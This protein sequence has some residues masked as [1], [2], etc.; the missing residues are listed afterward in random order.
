MI[1]VDREAKKLKERNLPSEWID[2]MKTP[3]GRIHV[4]SLRG[5]LVHDLI[6]KALK[7]LGVNARFSYVFNNIDPMDGMPAYL[8][9]KW[10]Q[11]M[12]MPLYKI[13]SPEKG[14]RNF[15][16]Y[17]AKEF[18][19]VFNSINCHPEIIWSS[20][21][22][23][24]GK[25]NEIIKLVLNNA[26]KVREIY[27]NVAKTERSPNW[28]PYNPICE[29]CGKIGTTNVF[30]WDGTY[31]H[32]RCEFHMVDWATGCGYEGKVEPINENGKLPWKLDW[33]AHWKIIGVTV[34]SSGK[35]HMSSGGSY[36]MAVHFCKDIFHIQPPEAMGGYEWFTI[37]GRKMSSSKGIG[38]S[39]KEA[40]Q[41]LPPEIFRFLLVR[42][43]LETHLDFD[44][45]GKTISN[46]FDDYD[47]CLNAYFSKIEKKLP[48]GKQGEVMDDFARIIQ[49]STVR[50][51]PE[52]RL[53]I[54]RFRT[55][56]NLLK[57]KT[58]LSAF[59]EKQKD[60][61]LSKDERAILDE[62]IK[63]AKLYLEN[64][65]EEKTDSPSVQKTQFVPTDNQKLFLKM[66]KSKLES[67]SNP[68]REELQNSIF[69]ILKENNLKPKEAFQGFYQV[70]AGKDY[71]PKAPDLILQQGIDAVINRLQTFS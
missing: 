69:S 52:K 9:K 35:D 33:P 5:V 65:A 19:E 60:S 25:M 30:K 61:K 39:A 71:G 6:Y 49:L 34:E 3:S 56:T 36:D 24:S 27:K 64:Y 20:E 59:F 13:P 46:L 11:Y 22:Y 68:S 21:L 54:P 51:L 10:E 58:E 32:Y 16:E 42:T 53:F 43:H 26:D 67:L 48:Q 55:I 62:R 70:L 47:R 12:G 17:F 45:Y 14:F 18:I 37:G 40:S 63:F 7:E 50:P 28:F 29:K 44:P 1:W 38:T 2:D 31:V 57:S 66:L 41:I 8:D 15:A 4:G 23:K